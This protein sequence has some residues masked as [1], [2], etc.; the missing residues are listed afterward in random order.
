MQNIEAEGQR[1]KADMP[2]ID[3]TLAVNF[4]PAVICL[5]KAALMCF[6][7]NILDSGE[8]LGGFVIFAI[9]LNLDRAISCARIFDENAV[10]LCILSAW[11][12]NFLRAMAHAPKWVEPFFTF[13][14]VVFALSLVFEPKQA[15]TFFVMYGS[16]SGCVHRR[17]LPGI[18][19]SLFVCSLAYTPMH[20]E[21]WV[22]HTF[23]SFGFACLCVSWVYLV[24]VWRPKPRHSGSCVFESHLILSRFCP[25]LYVHWIVAAIFLVVCAA[26]IVYHY[27]QI[28][29]SKHEPV[30][31][32][33]SAEFKPVC[34]SG[35]LAV[36]VSDATTDLNTIVEEEE[37]EDI[38]AYFRTACLNRQQQ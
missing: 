22:L 18:L 33:D 10:Q 38:E 21:S 6:C 37:D 20:Q 36:A 34:S 4:I 11:V 2:A 19:T 1:P 14:W 28:R 3:L 5:C 23:R 9:L 24:G 16:G 12:I 7:L 17:L 8:H 15:R 31:Q 30:P 13:F 29:M 35:L 26:A 32:E 27:V 25:V